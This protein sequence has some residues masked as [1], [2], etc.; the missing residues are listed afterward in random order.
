MNEQHPDNPDVKTGAVAG[1]AGTDE[2][3]A[4]S[5]QDF[6]MLGLGQ[7]A[8]VRPGEQDGHVGFGVHAANGERMAFAADREVAFALIR[9]NGLEPLHVH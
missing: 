3:V 2:A 5:M 1:A 6:A 4:M 9:Q 8:Y 7:V